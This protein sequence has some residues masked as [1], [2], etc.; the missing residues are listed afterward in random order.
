MAKYFF[1]A[2]TVDGQ[3]TNGFTN[4]AD[5][6]EV[7]RRI[8]AEFESLGTLNIDDVHCIGEFE[9]REDAEEYVREEMARDLR[10][11]SGNKGETRH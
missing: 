5:E 6:H 10:G 3:S 8:M 1:C 7:R 9:N 11:G 2:F 4:A